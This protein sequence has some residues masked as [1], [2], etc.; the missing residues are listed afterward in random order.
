MITEGSLR[1]G[2]QLGP[3]GPGTEVDQEDDEEEEGDEGELSWSVWE[4][5]GG[6]TESR[7]RDGLSVAGRALSVSRISEV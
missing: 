7:S 5:G 1:G 2:Y 6:G 3:T 4:A